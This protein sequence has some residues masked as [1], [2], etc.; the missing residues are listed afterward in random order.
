[1][2]PRPV[3]ELELSLAAMT[4][5]QLA[6]LRFCLRL[7]LHLT[8]G[9]VLHTHVR[10][11]PELDSSA[12]RVR[13]GVHLAPQPAQARVGLGGHQLKGNVLLDESKLA[14]VA[15][16]S[17]VAGSAAYTI[18]YGQLVFCFEA[19]YRHHWHPLC[20]VRW[21]DVPRAVLQTKA[22]VERRPLSDAEHAYLREMHTAPFAAYRWSCATGS[23]RSGH[24]AAGQPHRGQNPNKRST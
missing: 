6:Q 15:I 12:L 24:P 14:M 19:K 1:M 21:L 10:D 18:W 2:I 7:Y 20:L 4:H 5:P 13:S 16:K 11:M 9:G 22:A 3:C 8:T 23:T 17:K